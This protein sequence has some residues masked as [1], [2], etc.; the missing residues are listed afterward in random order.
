MNNDYLLGGSKCDRQRK[1]YK[2]EMDQRSL[3][4]QK[5]DF[6]RESSR[7]GIPIQSRVANRIRI[8]RPRIPEEGYRRQSKRGL[9]ES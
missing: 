7:S 9:S 5:N 6:N 8:R 2:R 3:M 1:Q 4:D